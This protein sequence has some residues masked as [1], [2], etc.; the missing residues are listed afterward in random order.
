MFA[1]ANRFNAL[2]L[3]KETFDIRIHLTPLDIRAL[4][5]C[6][7][8]NDDFNKLLPLNKKKIWNSFF[9]ESVT[10]S[11][12]QNNTRWLMPLSTKQTENKIYKQEAKILEN[13]TQVNPIK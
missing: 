7:A 12:K 11:A 10:S 13:G 6:L 3:L 1:I 4:E 9:V 5:A 8:K 2:N